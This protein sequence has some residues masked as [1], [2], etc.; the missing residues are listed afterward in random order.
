M[1]N[2]LKNMILRRI[3]ERLAALSLSDRSASLASGAGPDLIRDWRRNPALPRLDSLAALATPLQTRPEWLAYGAGPQDDREAQLVSDMRAV[4]VVSWVAASR[5]A[6]VGHVEDLSEARHIPVGQL[7]PGSYIALQVSGDSMDQVA[8]DG[9]HIIVRL[10]ERELSPRRYYVFQNEEG[11]TFKRYMAE[12]D[13]L[14]PFS[15]NKSHEALPFTAE[16]VV[17][18]RA[19]S[20]I[21]AI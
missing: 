2:N 16:T 3:D 17:I 7:P 10:N 19:I 20:V 12:P 13:R 5:F 21:H 1:E 15:S 6:E 4:P 9:S 18:G 14:E 8:A 11:A